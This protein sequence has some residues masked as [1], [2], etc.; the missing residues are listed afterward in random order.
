M[1]QHFSLIFEIVYFVHHSIIYFLSWFLSLLFLNLFDV[2]LLFFTFVFLDLFGFSSVMVLVFLLVV[3]AISWSLFWSKS[4]ASFRLFY[5]L[6]R[7]VILWDDCFLLKRVWEK[8]MD[9]G[10]FWVF[11]SL[12]LIINVMI[13]ELFFERFILMFQG[14]N[15]CLKLFEDWSNFGDLD[16]DSIN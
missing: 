10:F 1:L 15:F 5:C 12:W 4:H 13:F 11:I 8:V 7:K 16:F 14:F 3:L 9:S 2:I 6:I